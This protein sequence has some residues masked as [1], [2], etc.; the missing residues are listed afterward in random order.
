MHNAT[1]A[2]ANDCPQ[3]N[4]LDVSILVAVRSFGWI[5]LRTINGQLWRDHWLLCVHS[6]KVDRDKTPSLSPIV[7]R[8][9]SSDKSDKW[10]TELQ[11]C[12]SIATVIHGWASWVDAVTCCEAEPIR[13]NITHRSRKTPSTPTTWQLTSV[14]KEP[15]CLCPCMRAWVSSNVTHLSKGRNV[16]QQSD[17]ALTWR[18]VTENN[19]IWWLFFSGY[20][21]IK[22]ETWWM[23][24]TLSRILLFFTDPPESA[25]SA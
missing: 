21:A 3:V 23:L 11:S 14:Q 25:G 19:L 15:V 1:L 5:S 24:K 16:S 18:E 2:V 12:S 7:R 9:P 17:A 8:H 20:P 10:R 13:A 22:R 4:E 6:M